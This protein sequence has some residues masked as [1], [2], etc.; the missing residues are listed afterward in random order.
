MCVCVCVGG[1][2]GGG[3]RE[4]KRNTTY[5]TNTPPYAFHSCNLPSF[6]RVKRTQTLKRS[7]THFM[8]VTDSLASYMHSGFEARK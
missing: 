8:Y 1:G 5:H 4:V 3:G 6:N 7:I 2:G